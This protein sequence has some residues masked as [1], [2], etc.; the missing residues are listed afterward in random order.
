MNIKSDV[1][2]RKASIMKGGPI[3]VERRSEPR[4]ERSTDAALTVEDEASRRE[5]EVAT[6]KAQGR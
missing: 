2:I 4:S 6:L 3:N 5:A 1:E